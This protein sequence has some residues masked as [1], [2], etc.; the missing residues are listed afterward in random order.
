MIH[1]TFI[2][3]PNIFSKKWK[4]CIKSWWESPENLLISNKLWQRK[5]IISISTSYPIYNKQENTV[6][7]RNL[8]L[9]CLVKF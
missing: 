3:M 8:A 1:D 7:M 2:Y 9:V 6:I 4:T 5:V